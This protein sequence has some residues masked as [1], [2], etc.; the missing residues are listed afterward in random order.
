MGAKREMPMLSWIVNKK[1]RSRNRDGFQSDGLGGGEREKIG[2]A[3]QDYS[4]SFLDRIYISPVPF[5]NVISNSRAL[6]SLV[7]LI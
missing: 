6:F 4:A 5:C 2:S 1:R 3:C 7:F